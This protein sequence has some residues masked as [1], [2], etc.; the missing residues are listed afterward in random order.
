MALL[1]GSMEIESSYDLS[2]QMFKYLDSV[3]VDDSDVKAG[4]SIHLVS[5]I[6]SS[7]LSVPTKLLLYLLVEF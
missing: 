7:C 4:Y 5:T 2:L 3:D 6:S 1:D